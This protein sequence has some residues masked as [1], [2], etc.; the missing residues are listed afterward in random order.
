MH[1]KPHEVRSHFP[2]SSIKPS[3]LYQCSP[4][5]SLILILI[6]IALRSHF[7]YI[8]KNTHSTFTISTDEAQK[9][10]Q[11]RRAFGAEQQSLEMAKVPSQWWFIQTYLHRD[12]EQYTG[13]YIFTCAMYK[14]T[15]LCLMYVHIMSMFSIFLRQEM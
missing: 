2:P 14:L 4:T 12:I 6:D 11:L 5:K 3:H 8:P 1:Y 13:L 9:K 7:R 10:Q 15:Y